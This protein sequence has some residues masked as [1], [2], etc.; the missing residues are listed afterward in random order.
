M[1]PNMLPPA[2]GANTTAASSVRPWM[3]ALLL[4]AALGV[5]VSAAIA[6]PVVQ[7]DGAIFLHLAREARERSWEPALAH[8]QH[9]LYPLAVSFVQPILGNWEWSGRGLSIL[10]G[11]LTIVPVVLFGIRLAGLPAGLLGGWLFAAARYP[12]QYGGTALADALHGLLFALSAWAG[13]AGLGL[14]RAPDGPSRAARRFGAPAWFL[15]AGVFS[16]LAY[17][18]R[19][20]GLIIA[21]SIGV[22]S[23]DRVLSA[24]RTSGFAGGWALRMTLLVLGLVVTGGPY[25]AHL[26]RTYGEFM[27]TRKKNVGEVLR[28][29]RP[30]APPPAAG[31]PEEKKAEKKT[32][33]APQPALPDRGALSGILAAAVLAAPEHP[34]TVPP[35]SALA[36]ARSI[37][38]LLA[39]RDSAEV[40]GWL[41]AVLLIAGLLSRPSGS[42]AAIEKLFF[43][44]P[45]VIFVLLLSSIQAMEGYGARRHFYP[46]ATLAAGWTGAGAVA[47][48]S[49]FAGWKRRPE[50]A[51]RAAAVLTAFA[52]LAMIPKSAGWIP[53]TKGYPDAWMRDAGIELR[54]ALRPSDTV[55]A[56]GG[57]S[58]VA[59]YSGARL[60][61]PQW[62]AGRMD[63]ASACR[64]GGSAGAGWVLLDEAIAAP[65]EEPPPG[66][67]LIRRV[68]HGAD[69]VRA[70]RKDG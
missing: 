69:E 4:G 46:V 9:P 8:D 50:L 2:T 56:A 45:L 44:L 68:P 62:A 27:L 34:P 13:A 58:R 61:A 49:L 24:A 21:F 31:A 19:P 37:G 22:L 26:S 57:T 18:T 43:L 23:C 36:A 39:L 10:C 63:L 16:G 70:Y 48:A 1:S 5:R 65:L 6:E 55:F 12:A 33:Q 52:V 40:I 53:P 64:Q 66:W 30:K 17:L 11:T 32:S 3:W 29:E 41:S 51:S 67:K 14:G 28:G 35:A 54:G 59:F 7:P 20:E 25:A 42:P 60:V 15:A 38:V 47:I